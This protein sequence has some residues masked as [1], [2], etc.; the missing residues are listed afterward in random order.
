[1]GE[2]DAVA[3]SDEY[4]LPVPTVRGAVHRADP[5][6][7]RAGPDRGRRPFPSGGPRPRDRRGDAR[8]LRSPRRLRSAATGR[9]RGPAR[10]AGRG[11]GARPKGRRVWGSSR[12]EGLVLAAVRD[13]FATDLLIRREP[14]E[15]YALRHDIPFGDPRSSRRAS[16]DH[17][18]ASRRADAGR[19]RLGDD[20]HV[21]QAMARARRRG[22][23]RRR[24][25]HRGSLGASGGQIPR[26]SADRHQDEGPA[27]D[28]R[29][30]FS[31]RRARHGLGR[32]EHLRSAV[33]P[34]PIRPEAGPAGAD[35][36]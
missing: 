34:R 19:L 6:G 25:H 7:R 18:R 24:S 16:A 12:R 14:G 35:A 1:M 2:A 30:L 27:L 17:Q 11:A 3:F 5:V 10:T 31:G 22:R 15:L 21:R 36:C 32:H 8:G 33:D 13:A 28:A 9:G 20:R 26:H 23:R 4:G 29:A